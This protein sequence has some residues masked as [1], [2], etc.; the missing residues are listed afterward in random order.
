MPQPRA[1]RTGDEL[2]EVDEV[3]EG[4]NQNKD[5]DNTEID[6]I[7]DDDEGGV[8]IGDIYIPPA[9]KPALTFDATGP[10]LIITEIANENFKSYAGL[11]V[12]GPFHKSF[13][14]IIGPNGSGKSNVID[15]MLF[16]FGYRASKIRSKKI[17]VLIHSSS[18]YPNIN[19]ASVAVKFCQIID[20]EGEEYK[21][22]P[23]TEIVVTR[24]AFKDNSSYY[25]LNGRRVQF[26]EVARMLRSHGIDLDHNRFLILQGEVEQIAM[27]K[28]KGQT[29]H[30]SGMLE[31]LEDIIGTS[32]YK[33]P[34]DQL[35]LKVE[36]YT[37][38]RKEKLN[39]VRLVE[40]EKLK[41][42]QPMREAVEQVNLTNAALRTRNM[43][44]QKYIYEINQI[45]EGKEK[46]LLEQKE[47]LAKIDEKLNKIKDELQEKTATLKTGT[48]KYDK[49]QKEKEEIT[50]KLQSCKRK[51]VTVQADTTQSNKKKKN[52]EQLIEQEK[53][54]LIDLELIPD[55]NKTE[56]EECEK[57]LQKHKD[58]KKQ[59][60]E[61]LQTVVAGVRAKTQTFQEQKDKLQAKLIDLKKIVDEATKEYKLAE[62]ELK[63]Y[64][65]TET[66]EAEKLE[67]MREAYEKAAADLEEKKTLQE[68][69]AAKVPSNE[70][71][72]HELQTQLQELKKEDLKVSNEARSLRAQLEESRQ[73]MSANKSRGRVLDALMKEKKNG[74]LSGIFG[75]LGD[76]GGIDLKYDVA[77][78]TCCGALD[79]IVVDT[80]ETAQACVE[81]LKR[82][83]IGRATFI[84][85]DKQQHLVQSYKRKVTYPENA[86][87][88]FDLLRVK[89]E[90][91][92]PAFYFALRDT[93]VAND[94]EQASRIAYGH[95]RYRVVTLNGD[96]IEIAGTMSG[97]GRTTMRGRMASAVQQDTSEQD[98]RLV[99]ANENKLAALE[100]R[101]TELRTEQSSLEDSAVS[102]QRTT[103]EAKTTLNKLNIELKSLVEQVPILK[104]QIKEQEKKAASSKV[105]PKQK[106]KLE[107][108]LKETEVKLE[109]AKHDAGEVEK[110]VHDVDAQITAI[111]GGKVRDMQK[112]VDDLTKKIDKVST[113]ITKLRVAINTSIRNAKKSKDKLNQMETDLKETEKNLE[114]LNT[115]KKQLSVDSSKYQKEIE[116]LEEQINEGTGEFSGLK[117]EISKLQSKEN[118]IKS[119]RLEAN[120]S[121]TKMEKSIQDCRSKI[122]L[123]EKEL[124]S[125][126]LEDPGLDGIPGVERPMP[127]EQHTPEE[128][129]QASVDELRNKLAGQKARLGDSK[130]NIQAIQDFKIKDEL[131]LQR[132]AELEEITTKRN[133]MRTLYDDLK[134][135]RTTEFLCGFN[136]I[137]T[138]LKEMYQMIT[139]GGDAELELVDSLD[140][141]TEG[142]IFSVR[143][144]NKSWK[145]IS[146]L[147][148][149]EKTLS[150]LALVFAL[151]YYK[152]TPLYVMDEIDAALDFKNVSIVANYIK[153]RTRNAQF[154]I[155]SLRYNMFEASNRLVGIYKTEDCTKSVVVENKLI[156]KPPAVV[157]A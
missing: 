149:G 140:P 46:D 55:K 120:N 44:L 75:R 76:L 131:Y 138:K 92:L 134:K 145:N 33:E 135:K 111:A 58:N 81:H 4:G 3:D 80:V 23:N 48:Q 66:K 34:I 14:A 8:R 49:L 105:D 104:N 35:A 19:S 60:E 27:M 73:A 98:P 143:P 141:F 52:L 18:K 2:M 123:W 150:S 82:H 86:P 101:L 87:R 128:L 70:K 102:L 106:T 5:T 53:K 146:N 16:V 21:V 57:L 144:P 84:A 71:L 110:E 136:T 36:D 12:L 41:L 9:P 137:T 40:Q 6:H 13:T 99:Q 127:L 26:K 54:K 153:E 97:G 152:P 93:L 15:S 116:E 24:T 151:H 122:P 139:L 47:V 67:K 56:I 43:L 88:L 94:L 79:N 108:V 95:T 77:I 129:G 72:M 155:I 90:R 100:Q 83:D 65:S 157:E 69:L 148:G 115:Q 64:L 119:E 154:I 68:E 125:L 42:E 85:L 147:S 51:T 78:S 118:K 74:T 103:R 11:Q 17:S 28:P 117:Q 38:M 126:K 39:R 30:D 22:V 50:E 7:S 113:E 89:D 130:P 29:E 32:R 31:Y 10:R 107:K 20:G 37:E 114:N 109:K 156:E 132:A 121:F 142:V 1:K 59:A 91:V 96:V 63:I 124:K 133:E 25:T 62:S 61:E 45:I 112:N